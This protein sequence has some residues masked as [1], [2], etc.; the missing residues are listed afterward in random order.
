MKVCTLCFL[1]RK[2][3][4]LLAMKKR[5]FGEGLWNGSG[6]K[7]HDNETIK[8]AALRELREEIGVMAIES[9]LQDAGQLDFYFRDKPEW[10]QTAHIFRIENWNGDPVETEEMKPHWF[11]FADIP[12]DQMWVDDKYW[13]PKFLAGEKINGTFHFDSTGKIMEKMDIK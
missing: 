6:G 13:V 3:E 7:V 1:I 9:D 12:Y 2:D 11:K 4:I 8:E 10:D 5:G